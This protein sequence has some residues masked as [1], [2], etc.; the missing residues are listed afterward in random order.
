MKVA[1]PTHQCRPIWQCRW[2]RRGLQVAITNSGV[3]RRGDVCTNPELALVGTAPLHDCIRADS[4]LTSPTMVKVSWG[5]LAKSRRAS[6]RL[7]GCRQRAIAA[8]RTATCRRSPP[9]TRFR[10]RVGLRHRRPPSPQRAFEG[11]R[12]QDREQVPQRAPLQRSPGEP[13]KMPEVNGLFVQPLADRFV[14]V[15]AKKHSTNHRCQNDGE[16]MASPLTTTRT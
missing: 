8:F 1:T 16:R 3:F 4:L 7:G 9:R 11:L 5:F 6:A 13:E 14:T 15:H 2:R 12:I 10:G